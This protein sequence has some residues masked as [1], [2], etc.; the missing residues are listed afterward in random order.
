MVVHFTLYSTHFHIKQNCHNQMCS[1]AANKQTNKQ[2]RHLQ[3]LCWP[4]RLQTVMCS[5]TLATV[6]RFS[7]DTATFDFTIF[8]F[9]RMI[10]P[11][12]SF[13]CMML[14]NLPDDGQNWPKHEVDDTCMLSYVWFL[15]KLSDTKMYS[16]YVVYDAQH[17]KKSVSYFGSYNTKRVSSLRGT[18]RILYVIWVN[19]QSRL[20]AN[21]CIH[22]EIPAAGHIKFSLDSRGNAELVLEVNIA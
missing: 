4:S 2:T 9:S 13:P 3:A 8:F 10:P 18:D 7:V 11:R 22:P 15:L 21:I 17:K 5:S 1:T 14:E 20:L 19:D 6:L 16:I 12:Y